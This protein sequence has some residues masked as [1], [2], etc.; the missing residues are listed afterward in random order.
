[1]LLEGMDLKAL[2]SA[3]RRQCPEEDLDHAVDHIAN[4]IID[5]VVLGICFEVHRSVL[6]ILIHCYA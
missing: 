2:V 5:E 6:P 1:M 3:I 4:L